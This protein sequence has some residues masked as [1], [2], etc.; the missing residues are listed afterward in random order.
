M[1][2][3]QDSAS[4]GLVRWMPFADMLAPHGLVVIETEVHACAIDPGLTVLLPRGGAPD[5]ILGHGWTAAGWPL[6]Y[7]QPKWRERD[8]SSTSRKAT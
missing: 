2:N 4:F 6:G 7:S 1:T 8:V 5:S 3:C